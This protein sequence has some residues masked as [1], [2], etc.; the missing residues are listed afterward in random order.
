MNPSSELAKKTFLSPN[1]NLFDG[2]TGK[3]MVP[4][5]QY[6]D[7]LRY[8]AVSVLGELIND[9]SSKESFGENYFEK[10]IQSFKLIDNFISTKYKPDK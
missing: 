2:S 5:Y 8:Q 7:Y 3:R 6:I 1:D 4:Q 9:V 10:Q